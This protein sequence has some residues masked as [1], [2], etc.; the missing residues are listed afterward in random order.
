[1]KTTSTPWE[2]G[3]SGRSVVSTSCGK[4]IAMCSDD[5]DGAIDAQTIVECVN[6]FEGIDHPKSYMDT[7]NEIMRKGGEA[8]NERDHFKKKFHEAMALIEELRNSQK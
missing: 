7:V 4:V 5:D 1:M 8:A 3:A 6:A 2:I